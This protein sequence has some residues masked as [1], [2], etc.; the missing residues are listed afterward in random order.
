M[1]AKEGGRGNLASISKIGKRWH[2]LPVFGT[3]AAQT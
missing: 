3:P 1:M 2:R